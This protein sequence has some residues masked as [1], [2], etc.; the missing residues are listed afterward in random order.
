MENANLAKISTP[1]N[2]KFVIMALAAGFTISLSSCVPLAIGAAGVAV[3][4]IADEGFKYKS[5]SEAGGE[6][7]QSPPRY[8]DTGG[9]DSPVY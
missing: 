3:G 5:P 6:N 2:G 1:G 9:Y 8:D 7:S 4:F